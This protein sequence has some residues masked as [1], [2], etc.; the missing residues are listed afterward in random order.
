VATALGFVVYFRLIRTIG[1]MGVASVGYLKPAVG[2]LIG[3]ALMGESLTWAGGAGL[4]AILIGVAAI[5]QT[6]SSRDAT[7]FEP[8]ATNTERRFGGTDCATRRA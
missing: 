6:D 1:S 8:I 7:T 3:Y 4:I 5:N 2:V